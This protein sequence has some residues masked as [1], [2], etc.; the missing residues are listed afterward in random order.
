VW[1]PYWLWVLL[2]VAIATLLAHGHALTD[3]LLLDDHLH[4]LR[5]A[6]H[7]WS[8]A[9][10]LKATTIA[11][12]TFMHAWWQEKSYSWHYVRPV[13]VLVAKIVYHLSGGNVKAWHAI[14]ILLHFANALMVCLLAFKL[15][16][17][18]FWSL[19]GALLFVVY[20][21]SVYAVAWLAA[22]NTILQTTLTLAALLCY[23][24]A[25]RLDIHAAPPPPSTG[26]RPTAAVAS[27]HRGWLA[28]ALILWGL[29]LLSRE[30]AVMLPVF[31]LAFDAAFGGRAHLWNRRHVHIAAGL[32]A[33]AF[34]VWRVLLF[35]HPMPDFYFQR[36]RG[37]GLG[38]VGWLLVQWMYYLTASVWLSPM[39]IG[40]GARFE[41]LREVPGDV[42]LM[43]AILATL[44]LAYW[45]A[46]RR[47]RGWWI[48][49]G[50]ILL[51]V[52]PVVPVIATPHS[53][54][55]PSVGFAIGMVLGP[56]LRR[57]LHP[58]AGGRW[59][60]AVALWF[61]IATT[62]YLPIYRPMWY[63]F[64]AAERAT[65]QRILLD[66]PPAQA[67]E[68]FFIN[69]PFV[70]IYAP[71]VLRHAWDLDGVP[72]SSADRRM[73][74]GPL[75]ETVR[76]DSP[77]AGDFRCHVLTYAPNVLRMDVPCTLKQLDPYRFT[78]SI[79]QRPWF[80]GALGRFLVEGMRVS[81][82]LQA[83]QIVP[84]SA[85]NAN[86][87]LFDVAVLRADDRGVW[88]LEFT[89][90]RP[91]ASEEFCFYLG[92]SASSATRIR[93]TGPGR[94]PEVLPTAHH[95]FVEPLDIEQAARTFEQ[96]QVE[97]GTALLAAAVSG[98]PELA[99]RAKATF[100]RIAAP[101][102]EAQAS[103]VRPG[104]TAATRPDEDANRWADLLAWWQQHVDAK[105]YA[106]FQ[107]E[108]NHFRHLRAVRDR[109]FGIRRIAGR[110]IRSDLYLTGPP[111]PS[112]RPQVGPWDKKR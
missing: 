55:L 30:N 98:T 31:W 36:P 75:P 5:L 33:A 81:G 107:R 8:W 100:R 103:P 9:G 112:P 62:I 6:D 10:L 49:P 11:P 41:P 94:P 106:R 43:V 102:L 47:A 77:P 59:C 64:L 101:F 110:I 60:A 51:A 17:S 7:E 108:R 14:S 21:H 109:L 25:S 83:G 3:G 13:A 22:Q 97:A 63:S 42:I 76:L 32:L 19:V 39:T 52:L 89:F 56:G 99:E 4:R 65:V 46:T 15:T 70:N 34:L 78:V 92:T 58:G 66:P 95:T 44:G 79:E 48:W 61:L 91:L 111:Y 53:G 72:E 73:F 68:L 86:A 1:I 69:L 37:D 96:G 105:T 45:A 23:L 57:Q 74:L 87:D 38:Y 40:P 2:L 54:Y 16:R 50:W 93:F 12:E 84:G 24:R 67:R 18:R 85:R 28:G 104:P 35:D 71:L 88:E 80:S 82:P 29:A 27:L 90:H 26:P 20:S